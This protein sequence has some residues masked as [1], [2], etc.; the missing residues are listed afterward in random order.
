MKPC[1]VINYKSKKIVVVDISS[2]SPEEAIAYFPHAQKIIA[3]HLPKSALVLTD[4][5]DARFSKESM[6]ALKEFA[7]ANTPY[8]KAS[9]SVGSEGLREIVLHSV[10]RFTNRKINAFTSRQEALDWLASQD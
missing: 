7:A 8:I 6:E 10:E 3:K 2:T 1:E 5:T 4:A 9:A